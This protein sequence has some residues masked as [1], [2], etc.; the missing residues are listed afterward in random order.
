MIYFDIHYYE[1]T[2]HSFQHRSSLRYQQNV[3]Y[4]VFL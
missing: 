4:R 3:A 1:M 2:Q